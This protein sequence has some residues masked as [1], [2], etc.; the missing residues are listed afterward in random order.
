MNKKKEEETYTITP[1]GLLG[2]VIDKGSAQRA[3]DALTLYML[4]NARPGAA[5]G[6]AVEDGHMQ[7]VHLAKAEDAP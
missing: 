1:F 3:A 5:M 6:I 2:N 4:R 7:F